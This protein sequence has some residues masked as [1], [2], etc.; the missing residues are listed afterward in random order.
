MD[1]DRPRISQGRFL[2]VGF[3][4]IGK[5]HLTN[6]LELN[7]RDVAVFDVCED[8][9]EE[10]HEQF[11]VPV[12]ADLEL[13]LSGDVE[14]ALICTPTS[15]HLSNAMLAARAGCH[16]FIEKPLS[17]TLH[18]VDE[19]LE[20]VQQR[21][22]VTLVGCNFRFHPGLQRVKGLLGQRVIGKV[23]SVRAQF[24]Q[25]LPDWHP[26]ED[27][28]RG[29][30]AQSALG[31][32]VILDRIHEFDYLRWLFG[33]FRE[34]Y[35]MAEHLSHLE[36]DTEDVAEILMR[37]VNGAIGSVHL[38]YVRRTYDSS[39][40]IIGEQGLIQWSYPKHRVRWYAAN[41]STWESKEWPNYNGN[42]MYL[43]EMEHFL[44]ALAGEE[45]SVQDVSSAKRVLEIAL[46]VKRSAKQGRSIHL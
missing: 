45:V 4:S 23:V 12:F 25:Y 32:G 34:V 43:A 5:R 7:V 22:L 28:R 13:A 41:D 8:R 30:S 44:K 39:L 11:G 10:A 17:S 24:G 6:L 46:A 33:E 14:A 3:G 37:F 15:L 2:V 1:V 21:Q 9:R 36:I 38:D 19:L 35:S 42:E 18:G 40:E 20:E 26:H 27:Y 16:L 31:G 29:Y